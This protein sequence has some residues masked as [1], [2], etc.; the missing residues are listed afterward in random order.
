LTNVLYDQADEIVPLLAEEEVR[1]QLIPHL[2]PHMQ[3]SSELFATVRSPHFRA[4]LR[5]LDAALR[6]GQLQML[7]AQ[8]GVPLTAEAS[9][10]RN[11]TSKVTCQSFVS[12]G[13]VV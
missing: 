10:E 4:S 5:I 8:L 11:R 13:C 12:S 2:P 3:N 9:A 6:Q 7:L 1:T